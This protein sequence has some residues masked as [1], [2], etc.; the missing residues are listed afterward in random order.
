MGFAA[1]GITRYDTGMRQR[2]FLL[3]S[4]A[5]NGALAL[6]VLLQSNPS[7]LELTSAD[8]VAASSPKERSNA[9]PQ[10][11]VRRQHFTWAE[12]ES[13]DFRTYIENLRKIACPEET[14]RTI[15]V[16]EVNA[17]FERRKITEIE[18]P[19]RQWW[20]SDPDMNALQAISDQLRQ[21]DN[22]RRS[23]LNELLGPDWDPPITAQSLPAI[24]FD[25]PVLNQ[26][27]PDRKAAV[28]KAE[29][30]SQDA[31][32]AAIKNSGDQ[33][34]LPEAARLEATRRAEL[35]K[36][37][38]PPEL[39]EYLLRYSDTAET[40]REEMSGFNATADEF[41]AIFRARDLFDRQLALLGEGTDKGTARQR[42]ELQRARDLALT[43]SLPPE[44]LP[45]YLMTQDPLF[46][47]AQ[48]QVE[49]NG[50]APERVLPVY[51]IQQISQ[52]EVARI[53]NDA[54]LSEEEREVAIK[55]VER[56]QQASIQ[57]LLAPPEETSPQ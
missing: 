7:S 6:F 57:Q 29:Q 33:L 26:L 39:E 45:L 42:N 25:G 16:A 12:L 30:Q 46:R 23:L 34:G 20:K 15:I 49:Q 18:V 54:S 41:R 36:I 17:L 51:E 4:L 10:V 3:L 28:L 35:A 24:R 44:R 37:L 13:T 27:T 21:L 19:E 53:N 5:L 1:R 48:Q 8:D 14:I 22:Q 50:G 47:N 2:I 31:I 56:L 55:T 32:A 52:A 11:I 43:Q 38:T 40:L 9:K